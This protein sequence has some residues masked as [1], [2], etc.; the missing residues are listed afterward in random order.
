MENHPT[1]GAP[2]PWLLFEMTNLNYD[3]IACLTTFY[4]VMLKSTWP[5]EEIEILQPIVEKSI[6]DRV[7]SW[8]LDNGELTYPFE[9]IL[10]LEYPSHKFSSYV[11][12]V[13]VS[14]V[15]V[16]YIFQEINRN[17]PPPRRKQ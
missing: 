17:P 9:P 13:I 6:F 16:R 3:L 5:P 2:I 12:L 7:V 10:P 4:K 15:L 1:L 8:L 11:L 14:I